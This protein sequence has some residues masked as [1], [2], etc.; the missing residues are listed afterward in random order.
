MGTAA[1]MLLLVTYP[2]SEDGA[3]CSISIYEKNYSG[4]QDIW[5]L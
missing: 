1:R 5:L 2:V 3:N 4:I